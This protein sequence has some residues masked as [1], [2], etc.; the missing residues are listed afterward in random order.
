MAVTLI[1]A[2][3]DLS[4]PD[5][6]A[7]KLQ[8]PQRHGRGAVFTVRPWQVQHPSGTLTMRGEQPCFLLSALRQ[9]LPFVLVDVFACDVA[10]DWK[11]F[12]NVSIRAQPCE[13]GQ[14]QPESGRAFCSV[15]VPGKIA[16]ARGSTDC[17]VCGTCSEIPIRA[18]PLLVA[19]IL[20]PASGLILLVAARSR[21][22]VVSI[23]IAQAAAS[24]AR[25][26]GRRRAS[27]AASAATRTTTP[28][29]AAVRNRHFA[30]WFKLPHSRSSY[31]LL[32]LADC[33]VVPVLRR[34]VP[35]W[36]VQRRGQAEQLPAVHSGEPLLLLSRSS[37][38]STNYLLSVSAYSAW[39]C[40][41]PMLLLNACR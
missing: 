40:L 13:A 38:S 35:S 3:P 37:G 33:V 14:A 7:R 16:Q 18:P 9:S 12:R 29:G 15:C 19:S 2:G 23:L 24:G 32:C 36:N 20:L 17:T 28:R 31:L 25:P 11:P 34:R 41:L 6:R 22:F 8:R 4:Q 30:F 10:T 21:A 27:T 1:W 5:V 39:I 26:R